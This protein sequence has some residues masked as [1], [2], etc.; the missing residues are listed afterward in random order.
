MVVLFPNKL[1]WRGTDKLGEMQYREGKQGEDKRRGR[2]EER[3][4]RGEEQK[5]GGRETGTRE[6]KE[7]GVGVEM[8]K[9]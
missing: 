8:E 1:W 4:E 6:T 3:G 9:G 7:S 5:K 2:R